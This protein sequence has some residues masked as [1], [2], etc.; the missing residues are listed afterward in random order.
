MAKAKSSKSQSSK[1]QS[2]R[3]R[4]SDRAKHVSIKVSHLGEVEIVVPRG[5]DMQQIPD[6]LKKR[7]DW[8]AKTTQRIAAERR[9]L[10]QASAQ[11]PQVA[12]DT[13]P[14]QLS[15]RSLLEDWTIQYQPTN[16]TQITFTTPKPH[17]LLIRG[18]VDS[19]NCSPALQYWL[20]RKAEAHLNPWLRLVSREIDLPCN[21]IS[22]RGQKTL[23]ASCSG[24]KNIS[25]NFKLLF[26]PPHLVRYVFIHE[27][28]HTIHL[29]H[30]ERFWGLV[31]QKEPDYRLLDS[32]LNKAWIYI[33]EWVE[34]SH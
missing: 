12:R 24:S 8:I 15:L 13:F 6:I 27:L 22:V 26:L 34:S 11:L 1:S 4:I 28:C 31:E 18:N 16:S 2:Y 20:K 21:K 25:L 19:T 9:S 5:F 3:V 32:E 29:N 30:S 23:W 33:P 17:Q 10:T 7:Q 14:E